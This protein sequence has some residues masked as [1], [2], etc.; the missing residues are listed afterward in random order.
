MEERGESAS[1]AVPSAGINPFNTS[2]NPPYPNQ[3]GGTSNNSTILNGI[4]EHDTPSALPDSNKKSDKPQRKYLNLTG[5][6]SGLGGKKDTKD[7]STGGGSEFT[8]MSPDNPPSSGCFGC[9]SRKGMLI[10]IISSI[11]RSW[12]LC[13]YLRFQR[14]TGRERR[15]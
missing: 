1:V 4:I 8:V 14:C 6:T 2:S 11:G 12:D 15:R 9:I 5:N 7:G 10:V 3:K 13:V